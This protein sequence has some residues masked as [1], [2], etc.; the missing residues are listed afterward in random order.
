MLKIVNCALGI[1]YMVMLTGT[2]LI[3]SE[4]GETDD[5]LLLKLDKFGIHD[6]SRLRVDDFLHNSKLIINIEY[7]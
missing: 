2:I 4:E 7:Q 6:G 5:N 3:S 1:T